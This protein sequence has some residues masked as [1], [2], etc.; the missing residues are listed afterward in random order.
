MRKILAVSISIFSA[1]V[2]TII[3]LTC[4]KYFT[5]VEA[6]SLL[7]GILT[8]CST[9]CLGFVAYHQT[10]S[11]NKLSTLL[12]QSQLISS[13]RFTAGLTYSISKFAI[14]AN[15]DSEYDG[16]ILEKNNIEYNIENQYMKFTLSF[17]VEGA[18]L[19]KF[20]LNGFTVEINK[21]KFEYAVKNKEGKI[22]CRYS[23]KKNLYYLD[24]FVELTPELRDDSSKTVNLILNYS[25]CSRYMFI[26]DVVM[27]FYNIPKP[28]C[29]KEY[30]YIINNMTIHKRKITAN[31]VVN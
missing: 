14:C 24:L 22:N 25:T 7:V 6:A 27:S 3:V 29:D 15:W 8:C 23:A 21:K 13:V 11:A 4:F 20:F 9:S 5:L 12:S 30:E 10:K 19:D 28:T 18:I 1:L 2:I 31:R 26:E 17:S 16:A